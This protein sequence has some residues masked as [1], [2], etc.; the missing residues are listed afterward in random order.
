MTTLEHGSGA[1]DEDDAPIQISAARAALRVPAFRTVWLGA[2]ASGIGTWMQQVTLGAF[3]Y[4]LSESAA[5]VSLVFFAMMGPVLVLAL[6]GGALADAFDRRHLLIGTQLAMAAASVGLALVVTGDDTNRTAFLAVV[7][8]GGVAGALNAPVWNAFVPTLVPRGQLAGAVSLQSTQMNL[9]RVVGPAIGGVLY[10]SFGAAGVFAL[11]AATFVFSIGSLF[12]IE[13]PPQHRV[14]GP[15]GLGRI[16][17]GVR[18]ARHDPIVRGV[19]FTILTFSL[20]CLPFIGQMPTHAAESFGVRPKSF[21]YGVL[22]A[23]FGLG[24]VVG[25]VSIGTFL[26][27]FDLRRVVRRA[28]LGFAVSLAVFASLPSIVPAYAVAVV[29]GFSYFATVTSLSTIL[30]THVP[31]HLRGRVMSLWHL[32]FAG[33]VPIGLAIAGPIADATSIRAVLLF[34]AI[35]AVAL[36]LYL[37]RSA[38]AKQ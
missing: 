10:P 1:L 28:L 32:C 24:A 22:Y 27:G 31:D 7:F 37:R 35:A 13:S 12:L 25:A 34:G 20:V 17:E 3:A 21:A 33:I 19:L 5:F 6:V 23:S 11:N 2:L 14:E 36:A 8:A 26:S 29:L 38:V 15:T 18:H 30:Q 4:E 16:A 9:S